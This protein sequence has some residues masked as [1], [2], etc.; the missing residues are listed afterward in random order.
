MADLNNISKN[1][2]VAK[3]FSALVVMLGHY[4]HIPNFW[5]VLTVGMLIFS[6]SS[7][8]FTYVRYHG[9]FSGPAYWMRKLKRLAPHLLVINIFLLCLFVIQKRDGIWSIHSVVNFFGM[10]GFL[11]WLRIEN[12]SPFG[13]GMWFLTLLIL[14][15]ASYPL[16]EKFYRSK[17]TA[18][19]FTISVLIFFYTMHL[20]FLYGHALWLTASGFPIGLFIA[21]RRLSL[22][23]CTAL[24]GLV[25][26]S[27]L[28]LVSHF[29][30]KVDAANY[31]FIMLVSLFL[32]LFL[33]EIKLPKFF[34]TL[35]VW[36]S[37]IL[38]EVYLLHPYLRISLTSF[39]VLN[40]I[41]SIVVVLAVSSLMVR[42]MKRVALL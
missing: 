4:S 19:I 30:F 16:V 42:L 26:S 6:I 12:L 31:F 33:Q 28:M 23:K 18:L 21:Q 9:E 32:I 7:G 39:S 38:L 24:I 22:S 29:F 11:N 41:I 3:G 13:A 1:L 5:V 40:I 20:N 8:Y 36:L 2:S 34:V 35:G 37:G 25:L 10:N 15:Y 14:F 17:M 27:L